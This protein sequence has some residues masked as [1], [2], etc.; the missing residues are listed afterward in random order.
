MN[1]STNEGTN[2]GTNGLV[3][4][5]ALRMQVELQPVTLVVAGS[6]PAGNRKAA[7]AQSGRARRFTIPCRNG[8]IHEEEKARESDGLSAG[9][10]CRWNYI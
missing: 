4:N 2:K 6:N 1:E 10:E 7:V 9:V 5:V 3:L 8:I